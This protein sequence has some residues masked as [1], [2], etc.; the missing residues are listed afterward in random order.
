MVKD[1]LDRDE[2]VRFRVANNDYV[3]DDLV[4]NKTFRSRRD[5]DGVEA[6]IGYLARHAIDPETDRSL[7]SI[8]GIHAEGSAIVIRHITDY[9]RLR[10]LQKSA[11]DTLFSAIIGGQYQA[12]PLQVTSSKV[13]AQHTRDSSGFTQD[14]FTVVEENACQPESA[15]DLDKQKSS[16]HVSDD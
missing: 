3:L 16:D 13:L 9:R 12:N 1:V 6:D 14:H 8:A 15:N 2:A 10:A 11:R 4:E 7:I 5:F